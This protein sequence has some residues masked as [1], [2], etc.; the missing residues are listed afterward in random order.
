MDFCNRE[1]DMAAISAEYAKVVSHHEE[2]LTF[3]DRE[4]KF[5]AVT[6]IPPLHVSERLTARQCRVF[7]S[8]HGMSMASETPLDTTHGG[9]RELSRACSTFWKQT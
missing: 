1:A 4:V 3:F 5:L 6:S 7:A 8:R 2:L 9:T